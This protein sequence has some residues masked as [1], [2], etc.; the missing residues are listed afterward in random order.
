MD[1]YYYYYFQDIYVI[2]INPSRTTRRK[3][4]TSGRI[5]EIP[6]PTGSS[7]TKKSPRSPGT[8]K[9]KSVP[10]LQRKTRV[11]AA[12]ANI[13]IEKIRGM[14][15]NQLNAAMAQ[16][17]STNDLPSQINLVYFIG[18]SC[19]Q[20]G[21][22]TSN[23]EKLK[24]AFT[25]YG[26]ALELAQQIYSDMEGPIIVELGM[27]FNT[28][29]K[30]DKAREYLEKGML[31]YVEE[32][33]IAK[34]FN[35]DHI[36][37]YFQVLVDCYHNLN[38]RQEGAHFIQKWIETLQKLTDRSEIIPNLYLNAVELC[39][40]GGNYD[41][42]LSFLEEGSKYLAPGKREN[43]GEDDVMCWYEYFY[44][45]YYL[46]KK[47]YLEAIPHLEKFSTLSL[48]S[49]DE[50]MTPIRLE[51]L[52]NLAI[53]YSHVGNAE[54]SVK[55][56][57]ETEVALKA[58]ETKNS[59]SV[60][61]VLLKNYYILG[62]FLSN[63]SKDYPRSLRFLTKAYELGT[64]LNVPTLANIAFNLA[65]VHLAVKDRKESLKYFE[66]AYAHA[67][68]KEG[69]FIDKYL[70]MMQVQSELGK[71]S[72]ALETLEKAL[73][74][75]DGIESHKEAMPGGVLPTGFFWLRAYIRWLAGTMNVN[76]LGNFKKGQ[77]YLD[78][79]LQDQGPNDDATLKSKCD[80][81][82]VSINTDL[83]LCYLQQG[84]LDESIAAQDKALEL[85]KTPGLD[86]EG[87]AL[88]ELAERFFFLG[89]FKQVVKILED[90]Y[91][92]FGEEKTLS[93]GNMVAR[94]VFVNAWFGNLEKAVAVLKA[95]QTKVDS[96]KSEALILNAN[97]AAA[98]VTLWSADQP[99]QQLLNDLHKCI[100][101]LD[102]KLFGTLPVNLFTFKLTYAKVLVFTGQFTHAVDV[103]TEIKNILNTVDYVR[104]NAITP[105]SAW[106]AIAEL[107]VLMQDF[108][109]AKESLEKIET[110][111]LKGAIYADA[112]RPKVWYYGLLAVCQASVGDESEEYTGYVK[113]GEAELEKIGEEDLRLCG[114]FSYY[115]GVA[116]AIGDEAGKAEERQTQSVKHFIAV[117]DKH[118]ELL[119]RCQLIFAKK[120]QGGVDVAEEV[121]A[122]HTEAT[123][124]SNYFAS[125]ALGF[126][127]PEDVFPKQDQTVVPTEDEEQ[128]ESDASGTKEA[129]ADA[130]QPTEEDDKETK[131]DVAASE[132]KEEDDKASKPV[133][134]PEPKEEDVK[135]SKPVDSEEPKEEDDKESK[136]VVDASEP[137]ETEET[138]AS[139]VATAEP[140]KEQEVTIESVD[141]DSQD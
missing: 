86:A 57:D 37:Q 105:V 31:L 117:K 68:G 64:K 14:D 41:L 141:I 70:T 39:H 22:M 46:Q 7:Q 110:T 62:S 131:P 36:T 17:E 122:L 54:L 21:V 136:P 115:A 116:E 112:P 107:E 93:R 89:D 67:A 85:A 98:N 30:F 78:L 95:Y 87:D 47:E 23:A 9:P 25:C 27:L 18:M 60:F 43:P 59:P 109:Q 58:L 24:R 63:S 34:T 88:L 12:D 104:E 5:S 16:C 111:L 140:K 44:A 127:P 76:S 55:A 11:K 123:A 33:D 6:S 130:A 8:R 103:I 66:L 38:A 74:V 65:L 4:L 15:Q 40:A 45:L 106:L 137:K 139:E 73:K 120:K 138:T 135:E 28:I 101:M 128:E 119:A 3:V 51:C 56:I 82:N 97:L 72:A 42:V 19:A 81:L 48:S 90:L 114:W 129:E 75:C 20:P 125:L 49:K 96:E 124:V 71:K 92:K 2:Y 50:S 26:A 52:R 10:I 99:L 132:P 84:L 29:R 61:A 69:Q 13:T 118:G 53:A 113:L 32:K 108:T 134:V 133:D 94:M 35:R 1:Y 100:G 121:E 83:A 91:E 79:A 80:Q 102:S 126:T 77:T